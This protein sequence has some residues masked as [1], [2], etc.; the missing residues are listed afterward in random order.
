MEKLSGIPLVE[1][2]PTLA[3]RAYLQLHQAIRD[4]AIRQDVLYSENELAET[5]GMSRTPVR[6]AVLSLSREGLIVIESQRGFRLRTLSAEERQEIFDLRSLLEGYAAR[7]LAA[8]ASSQQV[9]RLRELIDAQEH[10]GSV[11]QESAFLSLDE[12]FHLLQPEMLG[13]E[14]THDTLVS[15]RGAMWLIGY[16]ALSLPRRHENVIAEHRAIVDAITRRDPEAAATA[17]QAHIH[18]TA[19]AV[20]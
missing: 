10:L 16:E 18:R 9:R 12:R 1:R 6:E 4:G 13:L 8:A 11:G 17:A 7:R 14:R 20:L 15:L 5:L 2:P 19:A 3:R